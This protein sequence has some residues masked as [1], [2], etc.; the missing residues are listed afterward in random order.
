MIPRILVI[1]ISI[2]IVIGSLPFLI[3]SNVL[4]EAYSDTSAL[5]GAVKCTF[6][7]TTF[8]SKSQ[9]LSDNQ[10]LRFNKLTLNNLDI[11]SVDTNS[12]ENML[13]ILGVEHKKVDNEM[14]DRN[15]V[16]VVDTKAKKI[17]DKIMIYDK[18][19]E[20]DNI[21]FDDKN[22][23]L[24]GTGTKVIKNND[25]FI[26]T[27]FIYEISFPE[28]KAKISFNNITTDFFPIESED[29]DETEIVDIDISTKSNNVYIIMSNNSMI[30]GQNVISGEQDQQST[31]TY[32]KIDTQQIY[33]IPYGNE[34][35]N[36]PKE[37]VNYVLS[38]GIKSS[39]KDIIFVLNESTSRIIKNYTLPSLNSRNVVL[40]SS[41]GKIYILGDFFGYNNDIKG[42]SK[43]SDLI[44][45][46]DTNSNNVTHFSLGDFTIQDFINNPK[47][48][49]L[50]AIA[51]GHMHNQ[52]QKSN[53]NYIL[54]IDT[55][56]GMIKEMLSIPLDLNYIVMNDI[57][58][59][60][61]IIGKDSHN[62]ENKILFINVNKK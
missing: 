36:N 48:D 25:K 22:N 51:K 18:N 6:C 33:I 26:S 11:S 49:S 37:K 4:D 15:V 19:I 57:S 61:F 2:V 21:L 46:I 50:Y 62:N 8:T 41:K 58:Q 47:N 31:R 17:V 34:I 30:D 16:I 10:L 45:T 40:D 38:N 1:L 32:K 5:D 60:L 54:D 24:Y 28:G 52:Q 59:T 9:N 53:D 42:L 39:D 20:L 13:Y 23:R 7:N 56:T 43:Q 27:N 35:I 29:N 3:N 55:K 44:T 14:L 12:K